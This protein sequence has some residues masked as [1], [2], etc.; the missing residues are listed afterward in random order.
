MNGLE[1]LVQTLKAGREVIE[2]N[3]ASEPIHEA[4]IMELTTLN[5]NYQ[6][7]TARFKIGDIVTVRSG[8]N[9]KNAGRPRIV[10]ALRPDATH[11]MTFT[12]ETA[13]GDQS[14]GSRFDV[15]TACWSRGEYIC[16]WSESWQL[17]PYE[18]D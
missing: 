11:D 10:V 1:E 15:R 8:Y 17:M 2:G 5:E 14:F 12:E 13:P 4:Q 6:T 9:I 7:G 18:T 3:G 16:F